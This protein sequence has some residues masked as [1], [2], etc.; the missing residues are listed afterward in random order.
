MAFPGEAVFPRSVTLPTCRWNQIGSLRFLINQRGTAEQHIKEGQNYAFPLDH[1]LHARSSATTKKVRLCNC[2]H[3]ASILATFLRGIETARGHGRWS[4]TKPA[5]LKAEPR[6]VPRRASRPRP[7]PFQLAEVA[8]H[9]RMV[10]AILTADSTAF[11]APPLCD[12]DRESR[13]N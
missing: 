1:G 9:A 5:N 6:W 4:L 8:G 7:S 13:P 10:R 3:W 2:T 12:V 11:E